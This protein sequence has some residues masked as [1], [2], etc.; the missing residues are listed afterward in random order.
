MRHRLTNNTLREIDE[1][2]G[3]AT[4]PRRLCEIDEQQWGATGAK[5]AMRN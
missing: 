2:Q 1:Q 4:G 5:K 3:G